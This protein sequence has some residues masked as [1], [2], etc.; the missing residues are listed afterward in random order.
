MSS[1]FNPWSENQIKSLMIISQF[2]R[3]MYKNTV[4]LGKV[5]Q[6]MKF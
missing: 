4:S 6:I 5:L 2:D 1:H 3:R